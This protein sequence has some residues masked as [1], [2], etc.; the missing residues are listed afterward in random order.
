MD[1]LDLRNSSGKLTLPKP[2]TDYLK[3]SF[4]DSGARLWNSLPEYVKNIKFKGEINQ[5]M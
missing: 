2:R 3:R 4:G 1:R 5:V